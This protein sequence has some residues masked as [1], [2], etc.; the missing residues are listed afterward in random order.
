[1]IP[2]PPISTRTYPLFPYTTLFRS[3]ATGDQLVEIVTEELDRY[4]R[5]DPGNQLV[6]PHLHGLG[7]LE[8]LPGISSTASLSSA[9]S[10][11]RVLR[12]EE[13]TSELQSLMRN[14]YAVFC[15]NKTKTI[16]IILILN[17]STTT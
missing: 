5:T 8:L 6:H 4:V 12:S 16:Q 14:S 2:R 9:T 17:K 7:K 10:S 3:L 11:S 13:H 15:L 1:M